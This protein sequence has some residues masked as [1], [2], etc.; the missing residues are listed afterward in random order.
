MDQFWKQVWL[1]DS[2]AQVVRNIFWLYI[3]LTSPQQSITQFQAL[4]VDQHLNARTYLLCT[5]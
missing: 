4:E 5:I 3:P 2:C 1:Q